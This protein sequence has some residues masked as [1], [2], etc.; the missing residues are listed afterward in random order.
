MAAMRHQNRS[1]EREQL[2]DSIGDTLV[3]VDA[4]RGVRSA[5]GRL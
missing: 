4:P 2:D 5:V 1:V 3:S